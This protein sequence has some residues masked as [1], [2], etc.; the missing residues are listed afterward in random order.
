MQQ[1]ENAIILVPLVKLGFVLPER[2][3]GMQTLYL[4][5]NVIQLILYGMILFANVH[6]AQSIL[7]G[8]STTTFANQP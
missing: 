8:T 6:L 7:L 1:L 5:I 2:R 4:V 3:F